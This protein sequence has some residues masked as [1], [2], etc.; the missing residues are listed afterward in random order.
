MK[1]NKGI[2]L[3]ALVIT[4]IVLIILAGVSIAMLSG[5]NGILNQASKASDYNKI[6]EASDQVA[7]KVNEYVSSYIES[8]YADG[9]YVGTK[10]VSSTVGAI[11]DA[12]ADSQTSVTVATVKYTAAT[13]T[14]VATVEISS[15][16][17]S[18]TGKV[19]SSTGSIEWG[20]I[21]K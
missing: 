1:E 17:Y 3:I 8:V 5:E 12:L 16:D 4:I 20:S 7:M 10:G 21:T 19:N 9:E 13:E 18:K 11:N 15:G 2:T 6:G 14:D